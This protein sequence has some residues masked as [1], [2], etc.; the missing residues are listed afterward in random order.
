MDY[1]GWTGTYAQ[2]TGEVLLLLLLLLVVV[3]V[4][5]MA[6]QELAILTATPHLSAPTTKNN[7]LL[8]QPFL[9][10][11]I[12]AHVLTEPVFSWASKGWSVCS[13]HDGSSDCQCRLLGNARSQHSGLF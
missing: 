7:V 10:S 6:E 11:N 9:P 12:I 8:D 1:S 5:V 4:V 13:G 2:Q 3:V